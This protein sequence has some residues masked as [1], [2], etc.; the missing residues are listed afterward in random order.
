MKKWNYIKKRFIESNW[1]ITLTATL[2]GV[3]L[4][5]YLNQLGSEK[6]LRIQKTKV[7]SNIISEFNANYSSLAESIEKHKNYLHF[8]DFLQQF[9]NRSDRRMIA[10]T[11]TFQY[12]ISKYPKYFLDKD[13]IIIRENESEYVGSIKFHFELSHVNISSIAWETLKSSGISST[14]DFECLMNLELIG[15]LTNEVIEREKII[16]NS[17]LNIKQ[18]LLDKTLNSELKVLIDLEEALLEE[19]KNSKDKMKNCD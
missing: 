6:E 15:K 4:A 14:F 16:T 17:V 10:P 11:D 7:K 2:V 3:F 18:A 5:L 19:Y 1:V 9:L 12:Y 8:L 13:S